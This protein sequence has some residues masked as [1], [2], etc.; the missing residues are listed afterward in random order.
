MSSCNDTA[1]LNLTVSNSN[2]VILDTV[3]SCDSYTWINGVTYTSSG[4]YTYTLPVSNSAGCD[5]TVGLLLTINNS[6]SNVE[7]VDACDSYS[8][9][10]NTYTSSGLYTY[11]GTTME[12]C[13]SI[14]TLDLTI[15]NTPVTDTIVCNSYT[16]PIDGL[17]Y[18]QSGTYSYTSTP[19]IGDYYQGG[20]V[21]YLDSLGGGLIADISDLANAK[22][23]CM[24]QVLNGADGISMGDGKQNTNDIISSC[25]E[26]NI[27]ALLCANSTNQGYTDW[28]LPSKDELHAMYSN[29][30]LIEAQGD[31]FANGTYW[32]SSEVDGNYAYFV[33]F[34]SGSQNTVIKQ[35]LTNVRAIRSFSSVSSNSFGLC[36]SIILNLT[37][38][39]SSSGNS[40]VA[41]CDSYVWDGVV[42]DSTGI[43]SNT[44]T[45]EVG[46]D[47]VHTLNLTINNST[48]GS[49]SE[50]A[51]DSYIWDGDTLT[52]SGFY[53]NT[54]T[55]SVGCDSVHTLNLTIN[56][57]NAGSTTVI[58]CDDYI[59][60]GI[61]YD[62]SGIY[63]NIY[64][65]TAGCDSIHTLILTIIPVSSS[66]D[67]TVCDNFT[68]FVGGTTIAYNTTGTYTH[69][70]NDS[71]NCVHIDTLDLTID[72]SNTGFSS[73]TACDSYVWDGVVYDS[74]G[75]YSNTYT[76]SVGCD[77]IHT[78]NL[79]INN[80]TAGSSSETACDS[81]V[82]DGVVYDSTGIYSNTYTNSVGC[83]SVHTLNLTINNSTAGSSSATACDSYVW[84]GVVYDSTGIYSNIYT[85]SVGCDSVHTLNLTINNSNTGSSSET[86]CDSYVWD[87]FIYDTSGIYTNTYTNVLGCDSVHTLNLIINYSNTGSSSDT[88]CDNYVWNGDTL[89]NSG[90][91]SYTYNNINGCDSIHT[92]YLTI[93]NSVTLVDAIT[94]CDSYTWIDGVTY[95]TSNNVATF[96]S[97]TSDGCD[98]LIQLNLTIIYGNDI[99]ENVT[100]CQG[101][102]YTVANSTYNTTGVYLDTVVST[103]GCQSIITTNLTVVPPISAVINYSS[104]MLEVTASGGQPP[105]SYLW[106]TFAISSSI[107]AV[108]SGLYWV[109]VSD[110]ICTADTAYFDLD[111]TPPNFIEDLVSDIK[112]YPNPTDGKVNINF[113]LNNKLDY[114]VRIVDILGDIVFSEDL[115]NY[116][117]DYSY[118]NDLSDRAKGIYFLE[119]ITN[120][121]VITK[122]IVLQ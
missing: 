56:N 83:D 49:S 81:Y 86:A 107:P 95:T 78:L 62:T 79:T 41:S 68:W 57:S 72:N 106:N 117:G 20:V 104:N 77:S 50:T 38:L 10:G 121:G 76:N 64:T 35:T 59:W 28:Y 70:W 122:K 58:V 101:E 46:C 39:D 15:F 110:D 80:S 71:N 92:L 119:I 36:D 99:T 90:I 34:S 53:I 88:A 114:K 2:S 108:S 24:G 116:V 67:T 118:I 120:Q 63:T 11:F 13:D 30:S 94:A 52:I 89:T 33:S 96:M 65:N 7:N 74:T 100:I 93:N 115:F 16:W 112:I 31:L 44:Y 87:G 8:W 6:T 21:F 84:D 85:N 61:I 103:L 4:I 66:L 47:S 54:Y 22:W 23:G 97:T 113:T 9:N 18:T 12:G 1:F 26:N 17:T 60:D 98:E 43:Y 42:Y 82:W 51:C 32:S 102:S 5:S 55:N 3:V 105:Y 27:A 40:S 109:I 25:Q 45:N 111:L 91:Y 75:I 14:I 29:R 19:N 73:E 37:I 69:T 48:V